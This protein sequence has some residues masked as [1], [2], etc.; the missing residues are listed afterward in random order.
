MNFSIVLSFLIGGI[1]LYFVLY[2]KAVGLLESYM[3]KVIRNFDYFSDQILKSV[4]KF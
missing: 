1:I 4:R 3:D 2:M